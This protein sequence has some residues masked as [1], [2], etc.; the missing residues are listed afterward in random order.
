[1]YPDL[2]TV[3]LSCTVPRTRNWT[4]FRID[5]GRMTA[6]RLGR[7][8]Q[9]GITRH[10]VSRYANMRLQ[11]E[12]LHQ[13]SNFLKLIAEQPSSRRFPTES[14]RTWRAPTADTKDLLLVYRCPCT[15]SD[16]TECV[17]QSGTFPWHGGELRLGSPP[18]TKWI[19]KR[20]GEGLRLQGSRRHGSETF[21][22][23]MD[24]DAE[25][26]LVYPTRAGGV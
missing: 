15:Q 23:K 9:S 1:M 21:R 22:C 13:H 24:D 20:Y 12:G 6:V 3:V 8:C 19:R 18:D 11:D 25:V 2:R 7:K 26:S 4:C 17:V 16:S 5:R 14:H 10:W